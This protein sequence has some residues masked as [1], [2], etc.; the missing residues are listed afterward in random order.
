MSGTPSKNHGEN[1]RPAGGSET[2]A[3]LE[4]LLKAG[5]VIPYMENIPDREFTYVTCSVFGAPDTDELFV[6]L[7]NGRVT[8]VEAIESGLVYPAMADRIFGMD[9]QDQHDAFN[10]ADRMWEAHRDALV[11]AESRSV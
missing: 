10:L 8:F 1:E 11:Q 3:R 2:A 6:R 5:R 9:V 4:A 7:S